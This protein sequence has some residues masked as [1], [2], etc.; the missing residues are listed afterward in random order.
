M[1]ERLSVVVPVYCNETTLVELSDR[2]SAALRTISHLEFEIVFVDDASTDRS[3]EVIEA[4][5]SAHPNVAGLRLAS[6]VGQ[7]RA[8]CAGIDFARGDVFVSMDA[9]LEH[10]PE[11]IPRFVRAFRAGH[12]LVVAQRTGRSSTST[13]V[14][15][16]LAF[17]LLA[18]ILRL[19]TTDVG[20][21][22]LLC[23][24]PIAAGL[25]R[26]VDRTGRQMLLPRMFA[27]A[28]NPTL[29]EVE[30]SAET[31]STYTLRRVVGLGGEFLAAELGPVVAR[32]IIQAS[33]C[34]L[35]LGF[36]APLRKRALWSAG[37]MAVLGVVGL[38]APMKFKRN[39]TEPLYEIAAQVGPGR[40]AAWPVAP[41]T[42]Q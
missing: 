18:R 42:R 13:R 34:V 2:V 37:S 7:L 4:M 3:W 24:P 16:S 25:R 27:S 33:G 22:F 39:R 20:S 28:L 14:L 30:S 10:P 5:A 6:N 38:M 36:R 41:S 11:A 15:G 19:P 40:W 8:S 9:D 29:L 21:S 12:D 17:N 35:L 23:T 31:T 32:R 1:T 26:M